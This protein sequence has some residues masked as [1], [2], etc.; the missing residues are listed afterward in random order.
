MSEANEIYESEKKAY[1]KVLEDSWV[2]APGVPS[3]AQASIEQMLAPDLNNPGR[4]S[5]VAVGLGFIADEELLLASNLFAKGE[6]PSA[7]NSFDKAQAYAHLSYQILD[8]VV[9]HPSRYSRQ[10]FNFEYLCTYFSLA[11]ARGKEVDIRWYAQQV[12]NII[13]GGLADDCCSATQYVDLYF[14]LAITVLHNEWRPLNRLEERTG[15]YRDLFLSV[16]SAE[17]I[18]VALFECARFHL[19]VSSSA[20]VTD[21]DTVHPYKVR[22]I[23][24]VAYELMGW[25]ALYKRFF[26]D[27]EQ[28][29]VHPMLLP[30]FWEVKAQK[31]YRDTTIDQTLLSAEAAFGPAWQVFTPPSIDEM[32]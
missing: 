11:L 15:I 9:W 10:I 7:W 32:P 29:R 16:G 12:Y 21:G 30:G 14:D 24:H 1:D 20:S 26:G 23:G 5:N 28:V 19:N 2:N 6:F 22:A 17:S 3:T 27:L 8:K 4:I 31:P 18:K 13:Q 25:M